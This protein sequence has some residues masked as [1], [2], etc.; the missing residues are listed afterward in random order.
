[1]GVPKTLMTFLL[2]VIL[3]VSLSNQIVFTSGAEIEKFSYDHCSTLC[4]DGKYGSHYCFE[5]CIE[6][7][8]NTGD[9]ASPHREGPFRCCCSN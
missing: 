5:D 7:G 9:C 4:V 2:L 8:F 1:M 6:K 3:G